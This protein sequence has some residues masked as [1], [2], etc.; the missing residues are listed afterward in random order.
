MVPGYLVH[1]CQYLPCRMLPF[2]LLRL[3]SN[4]D[5]SAFLFTGCF[6]TNPSLEWNNFVFI[7][8]YAHQTKVKGP[9]KPASRWAGV[10]NV[11]GST[12]GPAAVSRE[13]P[14]YLRFS[15]T[16][17]DNSSSEEALAGSIG[18]GQDLVWE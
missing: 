18:W 10:R 2:G 4:R 1:T 13:L 12:P 7:S 8:N 17:S 14:Y 3:D 6:N 16:V 15:A 11:L 5:R 9:A